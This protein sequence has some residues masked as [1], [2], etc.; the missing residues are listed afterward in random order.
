MARGDQIYVMR[1]LM[2]LSGVYEHHGI[3]CGDGTVI[4]Y[5]KTDTA[6]IA[7]TSLDYFAQGNPIFVKRFATAYIPDV[8]VQRAESRLGEQQYNL[9]S[10]NC[11]HFA[12]WCKTG[13]NV[14]EQLE[15]FGLG[16]GSVSGSDSR[17]LIA[18]A[19]QSGSPD[20]ALALFDHA[21][22][23]IAIARN[24]LQPQ[25]NQ[26]Q[27]EMNTWHQV[28]QLALKQGKESLARAALERKVTYKRAAADF[29]AQLDQLA[30]MQ[31]SIDRNRQIA[32]QRLSTG[33]V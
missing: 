16:V 1:P 21:L 8:V 19:A 2:G 7:R 4:H 24:H 32:Q 11:E 29:K 9:I 20:T 10:N 13:R 33:V 28:A 30:I 12:T 6:T 22:N 14:S 31:Q 27:A 18:E 17:P 5:R 25:Y 26:A 15:A 23:N 3:D